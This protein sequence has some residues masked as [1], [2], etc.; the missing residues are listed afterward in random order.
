FII[1]C[2][3]IFLMI[4][5]FIDFFKHLMGKAYYEG[6]PIVPVLLLANFFLGVYYN[7]TIWYKLTN[8]NIMGAAVSIFGAIVTIA[9]NFWWIPIW[10]YSGSSWVTLITYGSMMVV[11]YILGQRYYRV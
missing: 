9:L 8:K 1:V 11:S 10:G 6:L 4:M 7:L 5:L 3:F 2:C